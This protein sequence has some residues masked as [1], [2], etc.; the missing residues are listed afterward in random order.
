MRTNAA[1]AIALTVNSVEP[2]GSENYNSYA[3]SML[4]LS[5]TLHIVKPF[6]SLGKIKIRKWSAA[7]ASLLEQLDSRCRGWLVPVVGAGGPGCRRCRWSKVGQWSTP[8]M[9]GDN[10][11]D[12]YNHYH[13]HYHYHYHAQQ[14]VVAILSCEWWSIYATASTL[15][16]EHGHSRQRVHLQ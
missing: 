9:V 11:D 6:C 14:R 5:V 8:V 4:V 12:D 10:N 1:A 16:G 13:Y 7:P 3:P 2:A 15:N